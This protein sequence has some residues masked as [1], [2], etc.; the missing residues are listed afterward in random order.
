M[1]EITFQ[2][3]KSS[4]QYYG[5]IFFIIKGPLKPNLLSNIKKSLDYLKFQKARTKIEVVLSLPSWL[6]LAE[7]LNLRCSSIPEPVAFTIS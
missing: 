1:A 6:S 3:E 7:I 2:S 5:G 4:Y